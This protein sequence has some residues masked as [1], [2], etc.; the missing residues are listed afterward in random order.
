MASIP[1]LYLKWR[2]FRELVGMPRSDAEIGVALFGEDKDGPQK[3]SK[4]LYGDYGCSPEIGEALAAVLNRRIETVRQSRGLPRL[5]RDPFRGSDLDAS[6]HVFLRHLAAAAAVA[7]EEALDRTQQALL[8][9]LAPGFGIDGTIRLVVERFFVDR[10]F[11]PFLR[12]GGDGPV[13]FQVGRHKGQLAVLGVTAAPALAYTFVV[14]DPRPTGHRSWE[15]NWNET[16]F[17]LPSPSRPRIVD[18]ALLLMPPSPLSPEPGRFLVTTV[19]VWEEASRAHLDPR[20]ASAAAADLD[21][22]ETSRF[23]TNLRRLQRRRPATVTV[24]SAE[25]S[26][27]L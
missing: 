4:L 1:N 7:D 24:S 3:F 17:W 10:T 22:A 13:V 14:R 15:L 27:I 9:E 20:G 23:L 19:L 8:G 6:L 11:A 25:Y 21:E 18:G 26:V 16:L 12:S 2:A 5:N